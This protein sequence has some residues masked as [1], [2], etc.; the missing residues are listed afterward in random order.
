MYVP[1][2][3]FKVFTRGSLSKDRHTSVYSVY[4]TAVHGKSH[5]VKPLNQLTTGP[6]LNFP[7]RESRFRELEY[8]Y[9]GV[10]WAFVWDPNKVINIRELSICGGGRLERFHFIHN[11]KHNRHGKPFNYRQRYNNELQCPKWLTMRI[12][13]PWNG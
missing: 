7:F 3:N 13:D 5:T 2:A 9:N 6:T 10:V 12:N 1:F 11:H 4:F 8:R